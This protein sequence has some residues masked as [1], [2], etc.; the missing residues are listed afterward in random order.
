MFRYIFI[1]LLLTFVSC[2]G[3]SG[4]TDGR[5]VEPERLLT[6]SVY[7]GA[8]DYLTVLMSREL[9]EKTTFVVDDQVLDGVLQSNGRSSDFQMHL[10]NGMIHKQKG[11]YAEAHTALFLLFCPANIP[12]FFHMT[13]LM[14]LLHCQRLPACSHLNQ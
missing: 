10:L 12:Y 9:T 4:R 5:V 11:N 8:A 1:V 14:A 6:D 3:R 7:S 13:I 2:T